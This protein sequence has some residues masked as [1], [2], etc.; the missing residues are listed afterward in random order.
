VAVP[1][2][3]CRT[4]G[5]EGE[6]LRGAG[7]DRIWVTSSGYMTCVS[8]SGKLLGRMASPKVLEAFRKLP[9]A[10]RKPG[11]VRVPDLKPSERV[12]PSPPAGGL[13]LKVH[14]RFLSRDD[15]GGLRHARGTDFPLME[16]DP[17]VIRRWQKF[18]QP[19]T[20]YMWLTEKEWRSLVPARPMEGAK[21]AVDP[22][23]AERMARFHLYPKRS[24][25]SEGFG[26]R[27]K[28]VK[29]AELTLVVQDVTPARIRMALKGFVHT[30]TNFDKAKA[31]TPNGPL[32]Y[33]FETPLA[34]ILEYDRKKGAF[35]RFDIV[36]PGEVWGRW[37]DANNKSL[38]VERPGRSPFGFAF[39]LARGDSPS[40]R[41]PPGGNG[42]MV[43][44]KTGY[45]ARPK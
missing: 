16:G 33:G 2:W 28:A 29:K 7:I 20:E 13:V 3:V 12:I 44:E 17:K 35:K 42:A 26:L 43:S 19:N 18:L 6:F 22:A 30:G 40:D 25:T 31:T 1:T 32:A 37:G 15:R 14:A 27:R 38:P 24:M 34:G 9:E 11:A 36:A 10:E 23:I 4:D 5:P 45:F 39:E 21:V 8:A 41:L